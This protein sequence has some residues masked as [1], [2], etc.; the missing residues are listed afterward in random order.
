MMTYTELKKKL[1]S[2]TVSSLYLL[3]G[4]EEYLGR[5]LISFITKV[6]LGEGMRDFNYAELDAS[7]AH[8]PALLHELNAYPL[9]TQRRVVL[10]QNINSLPA[11]SQEALQESVSSL[12]DFLTLILTS[13]RMDRRKLLYKAIAGAGVVVELLPLKPAEVKTWIRERLKERGKKIT[14]ALSENIF[15]LTGANLSDVSNELNNLIDYMG[16]RTEVEQA[17]IDALIASRSK[18][19]IYKLTEH[20][21]D[22]DFTPACLVLRQLLAEGEHEL[23][24]LWHLDFTVKR[25]LRAKCLLEEGV[26]DDVILRNLQIR[27]FLKRRFFQQVRSFSVDEL[28]RMYRAIVE[29]DNKFKSTS[30][31]HP[32][33]D[34]ELLVREL[35]ATREH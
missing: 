16:D 33:I 19:P 4:P 25:L 24:I 29:W 27:P 13:E 6:A 17:D 15:E 23:R 7:T 20:I 34:M 35:C 21:A 31:W 12:P 22:R 14:A 26:N 5:D 32:D 3:L 18:E 9:G 11:P 8:P 2:D 1:S 28:R 30:R 10:I